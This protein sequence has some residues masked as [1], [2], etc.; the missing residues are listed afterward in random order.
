MLDRKKF[1]IIDGH[2]LVYRSYFAFVNNHRANKDGLIT[3]AT[4][5]FVNSLFE[6]IKKEDPNYLAVAFDT[7][8]K[9]WRHEQLTDYKANRPKQPED[10]TKSFPYI[11]NILDGFNINKYSLE[12]FEAD[13]VIGTMTK[14]IPNDIDVFIMTSD[15]DYGQLVKENV[16][17]YKPN[18]NGY[19]K[20]GV[21][22]IL[23]KWD[24]SEIN[25]V[26]DMLAI[27]GDKCD[28]VPGVKGIGEKTAAKLLKQ[29]GS[30]ENILNN[31][32]NLKGSI[33][34]KFQEDIETVKLSKK[35]VTITTDCNF[36]FNYL[37]CNIK[38]PNFQKLNDI[39]E[40]LEFNSFKE[41]LN[42]FNKEST[43]S[44]F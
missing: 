15:K 8:Y 33:K 28:N 20:L 36:D 4:F 43:L 16:Y 22:D 23:Q 5:G 37:D 21:N 6:L 30:L 14:K 1:F 44:L 35:L 13:D 17:L 32:D 41:R 31:I 34:N 10:I 27:I 9:T 24:I 29:Y 19:L 39:F 25:Q 26:I 18:N 38:T 7:K 2:A 42:I 40:E 3:S 12:G 11:F